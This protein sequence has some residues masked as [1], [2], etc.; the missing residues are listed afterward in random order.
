MKE[1]ISVVFGTYKQPD[2]IKRTLD[3]L[4][5][6]SYKD[7]Q[8]FIVDDN[9]PE[10]IELIAKTK[11]IIESYDDT[12]INYIKNDSNIGVPFVY[13][14]WIDLVK[15]P[16]FLICGAG[17]YLLQDS[18]KIMIE[19]LEN[20]PTASFVFGKE[21]F[22][23]SNGRYTEVKR[24]KCETG[25]Y[26][27]KKYL[28]FHLVGGKNILGWSQA[29]ALYRTEFFK[30]KNIP[31]KPYHYWDQYFHLTYLLFSNMVG[32]IDEYLANRHVEPTLSMW[33]HTNVFTNYMETIYQ[34]KRFIDEYEFL[35]VAKKY[36]V[37]KYRLLIIKNVIRKFLRLKNINEILISTS[38]IF[39]ILSKL[40]FSFLTYVILLPLKIVGRLIL[41]IRGLNLGKG[42]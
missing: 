8:I 33:S 25:I 9:H 22:E 18:L 12:R 17:D 14:K 7:L 34:S 35:L 3:S 30:V 1:K 24:K 2:L 16:Y 37:T 28:E 20:N 39:G 41:F 6:S 4:K 42:K 23:E 13:K 32:Y 38:L 5:L 21:K 10:D 19:F 29:S 40:F 15:T 31:I 26:E 11:K 36:P 27:P